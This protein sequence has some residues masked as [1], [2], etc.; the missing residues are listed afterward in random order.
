MYYHYDYKALGTKNSNAEVT[1]NKFE[2]MAGN[3]YD[4]IAASLGLTDDFYDDMGIFFDEEEEWLT[5]SNPNSWEL[6]ISFDGN[7]FR[8]RTIAFDKDLDDVDFST[9][10]A[11]RDNKQDIVKAMFNGI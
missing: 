6:K 8:F 3:V 4:Y 11:I 1:R 10:Q 7:R 9:M 2:K 5:I